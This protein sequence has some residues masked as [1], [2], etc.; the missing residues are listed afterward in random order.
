MTDPEALIDAM[1]ALLALPVAPGHRDGVSMNLKVAMEA[2]E[3]LSFYPEDDRAEPA[4]IYIPKGLAD[5]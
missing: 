2:Y 3:K 5:G 1:S 4:A